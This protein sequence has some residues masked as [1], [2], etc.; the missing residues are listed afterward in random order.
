MV[1]LKGAYFTGALRE[2]FRDKGFTV[3]SSQLYF[4]G[5]TE[6]LVVRKAAQ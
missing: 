5:I 2:S 6:L 4:F 3:G 1:S